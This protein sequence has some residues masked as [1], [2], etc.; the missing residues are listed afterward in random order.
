MS[1]DSLPDDILVEFIIFH[2]Y[3]VEE[4]SRLID[5]S[6]FKTDWTDRLTNLSLVSKKFSLEKN[7]INLIND[8]G[9]V[10]P[11]RLFGKIILCVKHESCF[12]IRTLL[13]N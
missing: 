8:Q 5:K 9:F 12:M 7:E 3:L 6:K 11:E 2:I 4:E 1:L 13:I 10:T